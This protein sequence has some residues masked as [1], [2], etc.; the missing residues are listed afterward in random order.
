[1]IQLVRTTFTDVEVEID[2]TPV[3]APLRIQAHYGPYR[4]FITELSDGSRRQ[5]R[6]YVLQ[7]NDVEAGFDNS[8]DPRALRLKYGRIGEEHLGEYLPHLHRAN[9]TQLLLTE[10][11]HCVDFVHW[12]H[13][14]L[15]LN[16]F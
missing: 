16:Q 11:M 12:L 3:R 2:T 7:G 14:H 13:Q 8:S 15:P 6:Y 10:E 5:Y 1:V 4:V 9:K